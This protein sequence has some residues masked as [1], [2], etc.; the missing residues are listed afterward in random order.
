MAH[1]SSLS[2]MIQKYISN[3]SIVGEGLLT[4]YIWDVYTARLYAPSGQFNSKKPYALELIY[5][6]NVSGSDI[7]KHSLDEMKKQ[8]LDNPLKIKQWGDDM[9]GIF[10][11]VKKNDIILGISTKSGYSIFYK[12]NQRVGIIK[13]KEFTKRFFDIWLSAETSE[14]SLRSQLLGIKAE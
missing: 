5:L 2:P 6:L 1:T 3:P 14:P 11:D 8:G 4:H 9:K 7:T 10:P 13:D 12:N